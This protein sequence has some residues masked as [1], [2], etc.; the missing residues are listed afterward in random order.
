[1]ATETDLEEKSSWRKLL[2]YWNTKNYS[3]HIYDIA[4]IIAVAI[5]TNRK[6]YEE[7]LKEAR[8][9]LSK[10][11]LKEKD[12]ID[13]IMHYIEMRLSE[14]DKDEREWYNAAK[15]VKDII[16]QDEALYRYCIDIFESDEQLDHEEEH[17]EHSLRELLLRP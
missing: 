1:M 4:L 9:L 5:F 6:V 15:Q 2:I 14:F 3:K 13:E 11:L 7:E 8:K 16:K 12:D 10:E 17:F